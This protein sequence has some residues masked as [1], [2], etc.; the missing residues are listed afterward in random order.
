MVAVSDQRVRVT[1][2]HCLDII[3]EGNIAVEDRHAVSAQT[4]EYAC[5]QLSQPRQRACIGQMRRRNGRKNGQVW[6]D[7]TARM[8]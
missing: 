8:A 2:G 4:G 6:A 7:D 3:V 5:L 1:S